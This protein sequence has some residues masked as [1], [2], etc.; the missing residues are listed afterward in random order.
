MHLALF[1]QVL[2]RQDA[3]LGFFHR[4]CEVFA[5]HTERL[6][7]ISQRVGDVALPDNARVL[8]LG[9]EHGAGKLGMLLALRRQW[10]AAC[11]DGTPDALWLHMVPK[12]VLYSAPLAVGSCPMFLWYTHKGVDTALK[13]ATPLVRRVFTASA[14]SFRLETK[15]GK[16]VVTGHGIDGEHFAPGPAERLVDVLS[17][18]RM[19]PSKGQD[20]LLEALAQLPASVN[21]EVAGDVLLDQDV[22]FREACHA[23]A[24]E[25]PH[26]VHFL[27][28]VPHTRVADAMRRARILVNSS[29]TGSV[30]KVVL[31]A[32]ACGTLPLTCNESFVPILGELADTLM[33]RL[34]DADDLAAKLRG[35]L[36]LGDERRAA[37][38]ARLRETV[39]RDHL[40]ENLIPRMLAEMEAA[41]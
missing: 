32:M 37:L 9:K 15:P 41:L 5:A 14:E 11:S 20:V 16:V 40:L 7:V 10:G 12:F 28:A 6:T 35:L 27:G 3:V 31:E 13:L 29:S 38:G 36:E 22:P 24:A 30:D 19:A 4:W 17:V 21:L 39:L 33:F 26:D 8:S 23:R 2:D 25:L 1:T 34:G 18:G